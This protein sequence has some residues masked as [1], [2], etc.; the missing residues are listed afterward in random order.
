MY[1]VDF[2]KRIC[3]LLAKIKHI[4]TIWHAVLLQNTA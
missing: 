4:F 2:D 1:I 3:S